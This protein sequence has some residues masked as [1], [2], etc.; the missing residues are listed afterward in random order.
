MPFI[1]GSV[2]PP[3]PIAPPPAQPVNGLDVVRVQHVWTGWNGARY[4][5]SNPDGGV[6]FTQSGLRGLTMPPFRRFTSSSPALAGTRYRDSQADERT[7]FW[8]LYL[9]FDGNSSDWGEFDAGFW[10]TMNPRRP[11]VWSV[12]TPHAGTRT[13]R[14]RYDSDGDQGYDR[15]PFVFGWAG[16]G[17]NLVAEQ[18]F[19]QGAPIRR[20]WMAGPATS[21]LPGTGTIF[22]SPGSSTA[23]AV[24]TN[25]GDEP[26][27]M[28]WIAVGPFDAGTSV[29]IGTRQIPLPAVGVGRALTID[30]SPD[31][32]IALEYDV[33]YDIDGYPALNGEPDERTDELGLAA[34]FAP[35]PEGAEV[36]LDISLASPSPAAR[37]FGYLTPYY[38]RAW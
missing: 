3:G 11:G 37:V 26:S 16:Y 28:T 27:W 14:C 24:I 4:E 30:T 8:P 20:S 7:I 6:F 21:F 29:G 17:V 31:R 9:Y 32:L 33:T 12:T 18:P 35:I 13:L 38:H 2:T 25:P 23:N 1:T 36:R 15:D 19:W 34:D 10:K 22:I 5:L